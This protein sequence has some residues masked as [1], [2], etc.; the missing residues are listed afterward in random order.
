MVR[1]NIM[2]VVACVVSAAAAVTVIAVCVKQ[3]RR[4]VKGCVMVEMI[5]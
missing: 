3:T 5:V 1:I 2:T 4:V